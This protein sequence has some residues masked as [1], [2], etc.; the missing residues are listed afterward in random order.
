MFANWITIKNTGAGQVSL[1]YSA[2]MSPYGTVT[3]SLETRICLPGS[4]NKIVGHF[5][6]SPECLGAYAPVTQNASQAPQFSLSDRANQEYILES[7]QHWLLIVGKGLSAIID[8]LIKVVLR[9]FWIILDC[10]NSLKTT[11]LE[12]FRIGIFQVSAEVIW[13]ILVFLC[14]WVSNN[15]LCSFIFLSVDPVF[16]D[17]CVLKILFIYFVF[18]CMVSCLC[19]PNC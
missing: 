2:G 12:H 8:F 11:A 19:W 7:I 5:F 4:W 10:R 9:S 13:P 1:F 17:V 16:V 18:N 15:I 14:E 6:I 3:S